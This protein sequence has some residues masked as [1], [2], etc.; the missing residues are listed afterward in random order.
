MAKDLTTVAALDRL[1]DLR[2]RAR[3]S[4][5]GVAGTAVVAFGLDLRVRLAEGEGFGGLEVGTEAFVGQVLPEVLPARSWELLGGPFEG[6]LAGVAQTFD[7]AWGGALS[8]IE[9]SPLVAAGEVVGALAVSQAVTE[10]RRLEAVVSSQKVAARNSERLLATAFDR[11]P[12]GMSVVDLEGR[13]LRVN[14]AHC[15]MLG[16]RQDE[17]LHKTFRDLTH[18]E[19]IGED[20]EWFRRAIAG[21]TDS[22]ER[23]KRYVARDGSVVWAH[24]RTELVRDDEGRAAYTVSVVQDITAHH[25][26][27]LALRTSERRLRSILENTPEVVSV[28]GRDCRY[29]LV[30]HAF[31]QRFGLERGWILGRRDD[32]I[33]PPE[34]VVQERESDERVLR[35][36][37]P[38]E[39]EEVVPRDGEDLVYLTVKFPLR[40]EDN[41]VYAVCGILHDITDRK[42]REV[43]LRERLQWTDRIYAAV[44]DDRLVL[45]GQP[46]V[47]LGSGEVEQ[48]E[49]L[50]RLLDH[51]GSSA[52]I[53]PGEFLPAAER[54]DL[55][56]VIDQ[57]V[58][59]HALDLARDHRVAINLSGKTISDADQVAEI[60]RL[61]AEGGAPPENI[62]FEITETAVAQN[63]ESARR[64]AER[65]RALGCSFALDDFGVGFGT[66]TYLKHLPVDYLKIDIEFVRDLISD[67][68]DRHVVHAMVGVARDF[69]MKTVA[70]GV[71]DQETLELL[72]AMGVD[73]A[74]GFWI[75]RP[76]PI[77]E[78]WPTTKDSARRE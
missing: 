36:G 48:A 40:D 15:R 74:Q 39:R 9:V 71:E 55:V 70:E 35:T 34:V 32:E 57:W 11:A 26:S 4:V 20:V 59:A 46:I 64:F 45:H 24:V 5:G 18:P 10:H 67:K 75:G 77:E 68:T 8:S 1:L 72:G 38:V 13:W 66:F 49:L 51:E 23:D 65:L 29:Q 53:A 60:E 19:D 28:K 31:E 44:S 41:A 2:G 52:L 12:I 78:L 54:F 58:V 63:L 17:L 6:A 37:E 69:G 33:L 61:V 21:Q 50:V 25:D 7:F 16:Y 47:N 22:L 73:Y 42:R 43:E 30:N 3:E 56:A 76:A 27:D 14:D 62:V